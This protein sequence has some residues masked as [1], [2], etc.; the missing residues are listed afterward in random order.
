MERALWERIQEIYNEASPMSWSERNVYL[1]AACDNDPL[2]LHELML[3][4]R[5][6][7]DASG[8]LESPV[9]ERGLKLISNGNGNYEAGETLV[10]TMV[11]GRYLVEQELGQGGMGKVYLARDVTLYSRKVVIKVLLQASLSD[12]YVVTKFRQEV[13]AL[14][15]IDH[16]NVVSVLG[17]DKLP[18]GEPYIVM[19]YVEGVTLRTQMPNDGMD[20]ERVASLLNQVGA[21]LEDVHQRRIYHRDLK[22]ENLLLQPLTGGAELVKIVDFGIAKV[23]DSVVAPSTANK[24]SVGTVLYMSPEQLRG[25]EKIT[26]ASDVYSMGV[27]AFEMITGRRPYNP[28]SA[29]QL[30]E[31]HRE[32]VRLNPI[33]L[34]P[35]LSADARAVLMRAL[36]FEP[37]DRYQSAAEFGR[38]LAQSLVEQRPAIK[39]APK[40]MTTIQGVILPNTPDVVVTPPAKRAPKYLVGVLIVVLIAV[41]SGVYLT[42]Q[43][44]VSPGNKVDA[45]PPSSSPLPTPRSFNYW[46]NVQKMRGGKPYLQPFASA[47]KDP[48]ETGDEFSLNISSPEPGFVYLFNEGSPTPSG[49]TFTVIYPTPATDRHTATTANQIIRTNT[50]RFVGEAGT[51]SF[52]IVWSTTR[53]PQLDAAVAEAFKHREGGLSGESLATT[54]H[55]LLAKKAEGKTDYKTNSETQQTTVRGNGDLLVQLVEFQHR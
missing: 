10:G 26:S 8:F 15:R 28:S 54:R 9:F 52:W 45:N 17:A 7:D 38:E 3:L 40:P 41:A 4:L 31:M 14:S 24:M 51:E 27:M 16:P 55:F 42:R 1:A 39:T 43:I 53:V 30:L 29:P 19:Q 6:D 20:L 25:G 46:L 21:A 35:T 36:M 32:G 12:P 23:R 33:D 22:P 37:P 2:L 44:L 18:N 5:A 50:N 47:G 11:S 49:S 48:F 13:E 34:R